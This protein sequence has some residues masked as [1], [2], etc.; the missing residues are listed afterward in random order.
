MSGRVYLLFSQERTKNP[1]SGEL[2]RR[3]AVNDV[4]RTQRTYAARNTKNIGIVLVIGDILPDVS[5]PVE[6]NRSGQGHGGSAEA[7]GYPFHPPQLLLARGL[8]GRHCCTL[9][10]LAGIEEFH[11]NVKLLP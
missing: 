7:P 4:R 6:E 5:Y 11:R 2:I 10:F 8:F 1:L 9:R 3:A